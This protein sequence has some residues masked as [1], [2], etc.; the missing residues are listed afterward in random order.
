MNQSPTNESWL[1]V[2]QLAARLNVSRGTIRRWRQ[3]GLVPPPD[4]ET[5]SGR[6]LWRSSTADAIVTRRAG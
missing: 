3:L 4:G 5:P 6:A 1:S 2:G